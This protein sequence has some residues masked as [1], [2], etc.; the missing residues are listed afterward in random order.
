MPRWIRAS[1][2]P[3]GRCYASGMRVRVLTVALLATLANACSDDGAAPPAS[4]EN[5]A[6]GVE[7]VDPGEKCMFDTGHGREGTRSP[8][9]GPSNA[10]TPY[11]SPDTEN[12]SRRAKLPDP[13]TIPNPVGTNPPR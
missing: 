1:H 9:Y 12:R 3:R 10:C 5:G 7:W 2:E 4:T 8:N 11:Y 13:P 6:Q